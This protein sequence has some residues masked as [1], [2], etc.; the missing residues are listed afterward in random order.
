LRRNRWLV[1]RWATAKGVPFPRLLVGPFGILCGGSGPL[2]C[3]PA[4]L[5]LS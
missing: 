1:H 4:Q 5:S 2:P 3:S